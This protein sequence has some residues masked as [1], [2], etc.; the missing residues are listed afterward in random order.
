[1]FSVQSKRVWCLDRLWDGPLA[2]ARARGPSVPPDP[3]VAT[4]GLGGQ[5]DN[6][7]PTVAP[8]LA[9]VGLPTVIN[10]VV[11]VVSPCQQEVVVATAATRRATVALAD[12]QSGYCLRLR[13][14][15]V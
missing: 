13:T 10:L 2:K 14:S 7:N 12:R 3:G 11:Q 1:M 5:E 4:E 9:L 6:I 15:K 8:A